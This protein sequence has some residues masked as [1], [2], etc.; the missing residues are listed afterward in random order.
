[1]TS[2]KSPSLGVNEAI[3]RMLDDGATQKEICD[4]LCVGTERVRAV[5]A[6][7]MLYGVVR[8]QWKSYRHC[9]ECG[10]DKGAACRND[11]DLIADEACA[12]RRL[13]SEPA[14]RIVEPAPAVVAAPAAPRTRRVWLEDLP[15][16]PQLPVRCL[17]DDLYPWTPIKKA[18]REM[19]CG[20]CRTPFKYVDGRQVICTD[21][22]C[23]KARKQRRRRL[24][25]E[26][27]RRSEGLGVSA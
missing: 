2:V 12:G 10:V 18:P 13:L 27:A 24:L 11:M 20:H 22:T 25:A 16:G 6:G 4:E 7:V 1:M 9:Y 17:D 21:P 5:K 3:K 26:R 19:C 14:E 23:A 8:S 15:R